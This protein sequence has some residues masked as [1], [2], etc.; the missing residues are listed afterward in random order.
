MRQVLA[1]LIADR[2]I[3]GAS[4]AHDVAAVL[5]HRVDRWLRTQ[6]D[7]PATIRVIPDVADAP[8]NIAD[9]LQQVD[10]LIAVRTEA[11]TDQ[12]IDA[13]PDWLVRLGAAPDDQADRSAWRARIAAHVARDDYTT[14]IAGVRPP[15]SLATQGLAVGTERSVVP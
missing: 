14:G 9:L 4:P 10:Q 2:P 6:V 8:D 7:D 1:S 11:L 5:H 12:A 3:D 13:R 15:A